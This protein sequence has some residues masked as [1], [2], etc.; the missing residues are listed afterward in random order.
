MKTAITLFLFFAAIATAF[1]P[2]ESIQSVKTRIDKLWSTKDNNRDKQNVARVPLGVDRIPSYAARRGWVPDQQGHRRRIPIQQIHRPTKTI[3]N[4][5]AQ[6][7]VEYQTLKEQLRHDLFQLKDKQ[8]Q[9]AHEEDDIVREVLDEVDLERF[10]HEMDVLATKYEY[11]KAQTEVVEAMAKNKVAKEKLTENQAEWMDSEH[12]DLQELLDLTSAS[13]EFRQSEEMLEAKKEAE[14]QAELKEMEAQ[15]MLFFLEEQE[16][17][18]NE[19]ALDPEKEHNWIIEELTT[20]HKSMLQTATLEMDI[21]NVGYQLRQELMELKNRQL[22]VEREE[23]LLAAKMEEIVELQTHEQEDQIQAAVEKIKEI[24]QEV[25][26]AVARK[27]EAYKKTLKAIQEADGNPIKIWKTV[28]PN[29]ELKVRDMNADDVKDKLSQIVSF[30]A[31]AEELLALLKQKGKILKELR[32]PGHEK[33]LHK[34]VKDELSH[35][36]SMLKVVKDTL[37]D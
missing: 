37:I 11:Q 18:L 2:L 1:R 27:E 17:L 6:L 36:E 29:E 5:V 26:E 32:L 28:E 9:V 19:V 35:H 10:A 25:R 8:C 31:Q 12:H 3:S 14:R 22:Q 34:W 30:Q 16:D 13:I 4:S 21:A 23:A 7:E 20:H 15:D 24:H 33:A